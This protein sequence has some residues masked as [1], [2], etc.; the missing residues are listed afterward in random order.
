MDF[1]LHWSKLFASIV[2]LAARKH[3]ESEVFVSRKCETPSSLTTLSFLLLRNA[4]ANDKNAIDG[5]DSSKSRSFFF[6]FPSS[7]PSSSKSVCCHANTLALDFSSSNLGDHAQQHTASFEWVKR[8]VFVSFFFP[9]SFSSL[10]VL[11]VR[12]CVD[13]SATFGFCLSGINLENSCGTGWKTDSGLGKG[14]SS[15]SI[16]LV[17]L[18][19][20]LLLLLLSSSTTAFVRTTAPSG[21]SQISSRCLDIIFMRFFSSTI[22][23]ARDHTDVE[24]AFS[25]AFR[26]NSHVNFPIT[27]DSSSSSSSS[28]LLFPLRLL[29]FPPSASHNTCAPKFTAKILGTAFSLKFATRSRNCFKCFIHLMLFASIAE[30]RDPVMTMPSYVSISRMFGNSPS[31]TR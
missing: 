11:V 1:F 7:F 4:L 17:S 9:S 24:N 31:G 18:S 13:F 10:L 22:A 2:S 19:S 3:S 29:I 21:N 16:F 20:S 27:C 28:L 14:A 25:Q 12:V 5:S 15:F 30:C 8:F 23:R 26:S 6:L